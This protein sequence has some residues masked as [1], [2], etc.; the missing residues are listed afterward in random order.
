MAT[1]ENTAGYKSFMLRIWRVKRAD[2]TGWRASL[3]SPLTGERIGFGSLDALV[4]YLRQEIEAGR[5]KTTP[6]GVR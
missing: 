6:G 1:T 3:E 5:S 4:E 2:A